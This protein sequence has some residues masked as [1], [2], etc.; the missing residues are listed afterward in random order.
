M[1]IGLLAVVGCAER[2]AI[3]TV[4]RVKR[5]GEALAT[6]ANDKADGREKARKK[7]D[8]DERKRK[9]KRELYIY[10]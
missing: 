8:D 3:A 9:G 2:R 6:T 7:A 10:F 1:M 5:I 4:T